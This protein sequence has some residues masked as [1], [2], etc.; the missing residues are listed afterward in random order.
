MAVLL[1]NATTLDGYDDKV[2]I[3]PVYEATQLTVV[4]ANQSVFMEL[5]A[6]DYGQWSFSQEL[7]VTPSAFAL[8]K[9][10]G[11]RFRSAVPGQPA[12][13]I[14]TVWEPTDPQPL[15][16]T[17]FTQNLA[18]SGQVTGQAVQL[19]SV[20]PGTADLVLTQ[21][22]QDLTGGSIAFTVI[23]ANA[24]VAWWTVF[25]VN[26]TVAGIGNG[27]GSVKLDGVELLP[28]GVVG[29][30]LFR[31]T[32]GAHG[33][34]SVGVGTHTIKLVAYKLNAGGTASVVEGSRNTGLTILVQDA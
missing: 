29:D 10:L 20:N 23:G 12:Q 4:V 9:A 21:V 3:G 34:S 22:A 6:G 28:R 14:A 16:S 1:N 18:A 26:V 19:L 25:D 32:V 2:S 31:G 24:K 33:V 27:F 17:P 11:A 30:G 8:Q 13:V 15:S 5:M 7:L